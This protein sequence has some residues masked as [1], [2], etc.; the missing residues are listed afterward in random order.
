MGLNRAAKVCFVL[1]IFSL[2]AVLTGHLALTDIYHAEGDLSLEW[3]VLRVCVG[4]MVAFQVAAL[5]TLRKVVRAGRG[6]AAAA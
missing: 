6:S 3:S 4:V 2:F 1:G 5:V